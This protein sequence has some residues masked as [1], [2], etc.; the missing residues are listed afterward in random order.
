MR[1]NPWKN[2]AYRKK[3]LE[4]RKEVWKDKKFRERHRKGIQKA[5]DNRTEEQK[6]RK[7]RSLKRIWAGRSEKTVALIAKKISK[8]TTAQMNRQ[9]ADPKWY[10]KM[11]RVRKKQANRPEERKRRSRKTKSAWKRKEYRDKQKKT[12]A[13]S[14][15]YNVTRHEKTSKALIGG[16]SWN[17][18]LTKDTH[19][20][21]A[22]FSKRMMGKVPDWKKYGQWYRGK[23]GKI[24]MRSSWEVAY[25]KWL[26]QQGTA[27]KYEPKFFSIGKGRWTGETYTPDFY[28]LV[29]KK[30]VEVKGHLSP[31]NA[32][33][34]AAFRKGYP[35][36]V[37]EM[38]GRKELL[39]L[40]VKV[41]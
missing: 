10:A 36:V 24:W 4:K 18:G 33:K 25:A 32:R 9:W 1:K 41:K 23:Q 31:E 40:G 29:E 22:A 34:M 39:A 15:A 14:H 21:L 2:S 38:L 28:L 7:S 6:N 12:R 20:T 19:P 8:K 30:Y 37:V 13:S 35:K 16:H 11:K 17:A 5:A 3:M 27:W 26:D